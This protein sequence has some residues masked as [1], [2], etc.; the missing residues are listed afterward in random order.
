MLNAALWA[1]FVILSKRILAS[2]DHV[3]VNFLVRGAAL[4]AL[5][6]V[7]VPLTLTGAWDLGFDA[8]WAA[9][10]YM[11]LSAVVTWLVAFNAYYY[12][13]HHGQVSIVVP[14]TSSDP[15]FTAL[16]SF[17]LLSAALALPTIV[18]L[19]VTV[20]GVVLLTRWMV[21]EEGRVEEPAGSEA[22]VPDPPGLGTDGGE[23]T[24]RAQVSQA[25]VALFAILTALSWGLTPI[26]VEAA[27]DDIGGA[28]LSLLMLSQG[29]G[30]VVL[31]PVVAQRRRHL[32]LRPLTKRERRTLWLLLAACGAIEALF[33]AL[34]YLLVEAV[35]A[36][37]TT[38][39]I[40]TSPVFTILA[41]IFVLKE[42]PGRKLLL[43]AAVTLAGVFIATLGGM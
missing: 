1:V 34:F 19:L 21:Q 37:L 23:A 32:V 6:L 7:G 12:A 28:S 31:L 16:Y 26:L 38:I 2:L 4:V 13:L 15:V 9:V 22:L 20:T 5:V 33:S 18:G 40:A 24:S 29:L 36:V 30:F 10:G 8:S 43:A 35:G 17:L 11:A 14:I 25:K 42:R 27:I 39:T 41:G 3:V